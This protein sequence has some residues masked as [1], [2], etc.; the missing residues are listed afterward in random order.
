VEDLDGTVAEVVYN[1]DKRCRGVFM[2]NAAANASLAVIVQV[3][4]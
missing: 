4:P 2:F 1:G 3:H